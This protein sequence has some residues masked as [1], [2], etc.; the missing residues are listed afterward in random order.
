[1]ADGDARLEQRA[2]FDFGFALI[3]LCAMHGFSAFK[4]LIIL[5]VN[6][7]IGTQLPR[8]YIPWFTWIFNIGILF[9]NELSDGYKFAKAAAYLAPLESESGLIHSWGVWLDSYSGIMRRWEI[10]FNI[11][12]LRLISFNMDYYFSLDRS[13]AGSPIEVCDNNVLP[14]LCIALLMLKRR[15]SSTPPISQN[16]IVSKLPDLRKTTLSGTM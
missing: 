8:K 14:Q 15:N 4:V 9:A 7:K 5:Y 1:V 3:F 12:V 11:T 6:H 16:V 10:L 2:S 13:R